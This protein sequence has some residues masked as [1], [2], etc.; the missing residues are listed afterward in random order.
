MESC[1]HV[2]AR[3]RDTVTRP[4]PGPASPKGVGPLPPVDRKK[5]LLADDHPTFLDRLERLLSD[6]YEIVARASSGTTLVE[7][8]KSHDPDL[9][10]TDYSMPDLTGVEA[11]TALR[12]ASVRAKVVVLTMH[13]ETEYATEAIGNGVDGYV[14]KRLAASDL[15][16]ALVEALDGRCFISK[17][18]RTDIIRRVQGDNVSAESEADIVSEFSPRQISIICMVAKG[19]GAKEIAKELDISQKSVEYQKYKAMRRL[20]LAKSTEL[21]AFALRHG[22]ID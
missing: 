6:E 20:G 4:L 12:Q 2:A 16:L 11:V 22:L 1:P 9:I 15:P 19:M 10:V 3:R 13:E 14:L 21:A 17:E 5:L 7:L 18:L 8:A